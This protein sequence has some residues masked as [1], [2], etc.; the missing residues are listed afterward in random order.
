MFDQLLTTIQS[1]GADAWAFGTGV[2]LVLVS[3]GMLYRLF[4]AGVA[5]SFGNG[6]VV[7]WALVGIVGLALL[8]MAGFDLIPSLVREI[9]TPEPPFPHP[10][11]GGGSGLPLAGGGA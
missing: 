3:L 5:L 8:V 11:G 6:Q 2:I 7:A 10:G 4:Q 9:P 1:W